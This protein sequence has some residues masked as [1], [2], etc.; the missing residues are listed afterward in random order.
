MS[1]K[2]QLTTCIG[3]HHFCPVRAILEVYF[4]VLTMLPER[5]VFL[6]CAA[7]LGISLAPSTP[8]DSWVHTG[9]RCSLQPGHPRKE[10]EGNAEAGVR[11]VGMIWKAKEQKCQCLA[12]FCSTASE[13]VP[14]SWTWA[15]GWDFKPASNFGEKLNGLKFSSPFP[16]PLLS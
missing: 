14:C 5:F 9:G 16:P 10:Q 8:T 7:G 2:T 1:N 4:N 6:L 13:A 11:K 3:K 12:Q 15:W